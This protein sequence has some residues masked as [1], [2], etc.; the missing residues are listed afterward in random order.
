MTVYRDYKQEEKI[1][2][3]YK[4]VFDSDEKV[5]EVRESKEKRFSWTNKVNE[6][7]KKAI[8]DSCGKSH[9]KKKKKKTDE[10]D[11]KK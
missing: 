9:D 10:E 1:N 6:A 2:D 5:K 7:Y 4:K 8:D 11:E 3:A